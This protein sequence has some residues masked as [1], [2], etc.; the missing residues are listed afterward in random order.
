MKLGVPGG[1]FVADVQDNRRFQT[2][3]PY[4][5]GFEIKERWQTGTVSGVI[6]IDDEYYCDVSGSPIRTQFPDIVFYDGRRGAGD[7]GEGDNAVSVKTL[8]NG[9]T[10]EMDYEYNPATSI[11]GAPVHLFGYVPITALDTNN[12]F[13]KK[14]SFVANSGVKFGKAATHSRQTEAAILDVVSM[15]DMAGGLEAFKWQ[16]GKGIDKDGFVIGMKNASISGIDSFLDE[17]ITTLMS[18]VI[19][20]GDPATMKDYQEASDLLPDDYYD[21]ADDHDTDQQLWKKW[22]NTLRLNYERQSHTNP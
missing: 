2:L 14:L 3:K 11:P 17:H 1:G 19:Y 6:K 7:S 15:V 18:H 22:W 12:N 21:G 4:W 8:P 5:K 9:F 13:T 16:N 10:L 20:G